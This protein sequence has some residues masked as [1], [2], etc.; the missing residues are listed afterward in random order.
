MKDTHS[1]TDQLLTTIT[2]YVHSYEI[3]DP[4]LLDQAKVCLLDS[5]ACAMLALK[6]EKCKGLL[7]PILPGTIVP[8]GS[9]VPGTEFVLDPILASFNLGAMIRWL[10]FNDTW[11]AAEWGHP[12]DNISA[13]LSVADYM[14]QTSAMDMR[15]VLEAMIKAYEIQ[16]ILSLENSFNSL[17]IDHVILVKIASCAL[18]SWLLGGGK[19]Q[20]LNAI[21]HAWIDGQSLRTYRHGINTSSRKSWAAGDAAARGVRLAW[22]AKHGETG[23]P[24]ALTTPLWGFEDA[25]MHG[26]PIII[27]QPLDRYVMDN[28]LFKV[29]FPAEFHAQTALEAA[30]TLHPLVAD[31]L[32]KISRIEV[33]TQAAAMKII[34][35]SGKL[36]NYADRDHCL[37]YIVAVGLIYGNLDANSYSDEFAAKDPRIDQIRAKIIVAEDLAYSRA[38]YDPQKRAIANSVQ[39]FYQDGS[40]SSKVELYYPV[41]HKF[42]RE[43]AEPLLKKKYLQ[44]IQPHFNQQQIETL[45]DLWAIN[46]MELAQI[47]V[48]QFMDMWTKK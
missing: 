46:V 41:G 25:V 43:E 4:N 18:S 10:D 14:S 24:Q 27:K 32:D 15:K 30:I 36:S 21:S 47:P 5:L 6:E 37:Q 40:C 31:K 39:V 23:Y 35:K 45:Q 48:K 16:G 22:L 33:H 29:E 38:Y 7:G 17:G 1:I 3:T 20:T 9:R 2:E 8:N 28:I 44:A 34:N 42:R 19:T 11:L 13:I 12:S 26:R